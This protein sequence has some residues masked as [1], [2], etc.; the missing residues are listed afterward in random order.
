MDKKIISLLILGCLAAMFFAGCGSNAKNQ[1]LETT[2]V[3]STLHTFD[4]DYSKN[5]DGIYTCR[6][7]SFKYKIEVPRTEGT[8]KSGGF[9]ILTNDKDVSF[10]TVSD[11]LSSSKAATGEPEFIILGWY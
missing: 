11:S 1:N 2:E 9:V 6:G 7:Y 5:E 8:A 3:K 4:V 10:E